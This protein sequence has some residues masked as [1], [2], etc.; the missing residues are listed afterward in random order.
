M[1]FIEFLILLYELV[2]SF[3]F[4]FIICEFGERVSGTFNGINDA[5][6]QFDW[7]LLSI[8]AQ[9]MLPTIINFAQQPTIFEITGDISTTREFFKKANQI[10]TFYQ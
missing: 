8:E 3:L 4:I 6:D 9:K 5:L 2:G 10:K 7:Y 1:D